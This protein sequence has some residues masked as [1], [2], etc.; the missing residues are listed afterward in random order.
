MTSSPKRPGVAF[1]ATVVVLVALIAYPLSF[2][3]ACRIYTTNVTLFWTPLRLVYSP[4]VAVCCRLPD[5][6]R[7]AACWYVELFL[8]AGFHFTPTKW[9]FD[10][11]WF[12]KNG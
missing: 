6:P 8:P 1:W 2:G 12:E 11:A 10:V 7:Y 3:P 4:L 9:K 5:G